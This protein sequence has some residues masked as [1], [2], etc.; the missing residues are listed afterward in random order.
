M[1]GCPS[2]TKRSVRHRALSILHP[3]PSRVARVDLEHL[4][5]VVHAALHAIDE[6][7]R[8]APVAHRLVK[9]TVR[10][11]ARARARAIP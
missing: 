11:R 9:V 7:L 10:V 6:A 8:V 4:A 1:T 3:G 5:H 2:L